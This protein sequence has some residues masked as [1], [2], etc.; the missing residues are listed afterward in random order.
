MASRFDRVATTISQSIETMRLAEVE[1]PHVG[2][3]AVSDGFIGL[4]NA[5]AGTAVAVLGSYA[6][7]LLQ[8]GHE[9]A[10]GLLGD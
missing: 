8:G 3:F 6:Y 5:A 4:V 2:G 10:V 9:E 1:G 7:A